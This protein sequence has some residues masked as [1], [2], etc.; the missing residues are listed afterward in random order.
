MNSGE[1]DTGTVQE[2]STGLTPTRE[3]AN[4]NPWNS[5]RTSNYSA[6]RL[7]IA[8]LSRLMASIYVPSL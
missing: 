4:L 1:G 2:G 3:F 8:S 6:A 5:R 7:G